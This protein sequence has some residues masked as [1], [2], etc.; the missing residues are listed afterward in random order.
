[1]SRAVMLD[2]ITGDTTLA[3]L[4]FDDTSV[5]PNYDAEQRL[6]DEMFIVLRWGTDDIGLTGD[7]STVKIGPRNVDVWV[8]MYRELSSDFNRIDSVIDRLDQVLSNIID[9]PGSDGRTVS[10]IIP[11][12]RSRD[13]K[14]DGY[15]TFC[16]SASYQVFS[17]VT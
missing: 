9:V 17:R 4:G 14:D 2:A 6:N 15:Y 1:M 5:V 16:R 7:D 3:G 13:L 8:H 10:Q 11:K 12:G